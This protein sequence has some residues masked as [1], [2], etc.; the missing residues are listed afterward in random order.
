MDQRTRKLI[1]MHK[2]LNPHRLTICQ[3]KKNAEQSPALKIG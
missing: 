2:A 1:M 3:E